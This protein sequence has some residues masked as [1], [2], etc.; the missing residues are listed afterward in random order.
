[1][2]CIEEVGGVNIDAS[3]SNIDKFITERPNDLNLNIAVGSK[4]EIKKL[5]LI[6]G[7]TRST[8]DE[9]LGKDYIRR[10]LP[11][12]EID[13]MT[14]TLTSILEENEVPSSPDLLSI[15]VEGHE[16]DIFE[17]L[18][19]TRFTPKLVVVEATYPETPRVVSHLWSNYLYDYG[20]EQV[21]FDGLNAY[22]YHNPTDE[23]KALLKHPANYFDNFV[24][25]DM[26]SSLVAALNKK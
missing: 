7:S 23:V 25:Y 3:K 5:Y 8:F 20:Y 17:G 18:D 14:K 26:L 13:V 21:F 22:F 12:K 6:D 16:S 4:N 2:P 11:V 15:D 9:E 24:S 1:M 10:G 19:F